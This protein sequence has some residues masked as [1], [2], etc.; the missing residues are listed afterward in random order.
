MT[1][2][3]SVAASL[4]EITLLSCLP[5]THV[6]PDTV[7]P[8]HAHFDMTGGRVTRPSKH[9]WASPCCLASHANREHKDAVSKMSLQAYFDMTG[10][11]ITLHSKLRVSVP[12]PA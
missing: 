2:I 3:L 9:T 6:F 4:P 11:R 8:T 12:L 1:E 10:G 7:G 5:F